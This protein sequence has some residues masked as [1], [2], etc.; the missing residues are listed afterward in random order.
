MADV[1]LV[2]PDVILGK[3]YTHALQI[4]GHRV[5]WETTAQPAIAAVDQKLPDVIIVELDAPLHN[6]VE[7][8]YELRSY[9]DC[10]DIPVFVLGHLPKATITRNAQWQR[11]N[12]SYYYKPRTKLSQL[13]SMIAAECQAA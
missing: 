12:A 5:R 4:N 8:L 13:L 11:L 1:L 7:F 3:I 6:G 10:R 2:E 9:R